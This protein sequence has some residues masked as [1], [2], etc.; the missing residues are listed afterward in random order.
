MLVLA[1]KKGESIMIG[2]QIEIVILST[3]GDTIRIGINAPKN[4]EV[5]RK[6]VF[7]QIKEA[8]M[9]ASKHTVSPANISLL[10]NKIK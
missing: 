1:R 7:L 8:N 6:E 10:F 9:D 2:D 4:V 5:Y 3:D